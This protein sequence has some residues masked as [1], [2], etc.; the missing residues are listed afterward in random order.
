MDCGPHESRCLGRTGGLLISL[1]A[2][3]VIFCGQ[4][5]PESKTGSLEKRLE[6][7][8]SVPY[9]SLTE[10][11]GGE[12]SGV[13]LH[14]ESRA[15][16]G[17]NLYCSRTSPEA[18]LIDMNGAV[19]HRWSYT[20]DDDRTWD[21]ALLLEGG[22]LMVLNKFVNVFKLDRHSDLIWER[23]LEVHHE[24]VK[25]ADGNFYVIQR[26]KRPYRGVEVRF[27]S[28]LH[29]DPDGNTLDR[30]STYDSLEEIRQEF[31][32]RSF[33]DNILDSLDAG[34]VSAGDA[35]AVNPA[36]R[37]L[38][39]N[40]KVYDYFHLNAVTLLPD[41]PLGRKDPRFAEGNLLIC[42]RNINQIAVLDRSSKEI[43][44][45]WG[46]GRLEWPHH[47][48]MV[49]NGNI[50]VFDNGVVRGYSRV[51]EINPL[52]GKIEW[53][54]LGSPPPVFYSPRKGSAQRLPNGNTLICEGDRGRT[55]EVT[56][57]GEIVWDWLNPH[58]EEGR[59]VQVYRM[60]RY[61]PNQVEAWIGR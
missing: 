53:K 44:W 31:D 58:F 27:A 5:A 6:Q 7:L 34:D 52:N 8:R 38:V 32:R 60:I 61:G 30:W 51:V 47:P 14:D 26:E 50:L 41:T 24:I 20:Q 23:S 49:E 22:D 2:L 13:T 10:E 4:E 43:T 11:V 29:L 48:T 18:Y 1:A 37:R 55:F 9:T 12:S 36:A 59:R 57:G 17:Y 35:P 42:L 25:D 3:L 54:Y 16:P 15:W 39:G 28:I 40:P 19:V 56:S 21:H 45:V 46:E 33:L